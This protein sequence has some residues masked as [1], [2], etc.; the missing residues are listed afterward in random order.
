MRD[1][2]PIYG[3]YGYSSALDAWI[4]QQGDKGLETETLANTRQGKSDEGQPKAK[5]GKAKAKKKG[6]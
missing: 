4:I 6:E 2:L 5:K 1:G 3:P